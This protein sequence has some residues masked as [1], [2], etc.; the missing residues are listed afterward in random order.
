MTSTTKPIEVE[1]G[2]TL[3]SGIN[4]ISQHQIKNEKAGFSVD[5]PGNVTCCGEAAVQTILPRTRIVVPGAL[6]IRAARISAAVTDNLTLNR[7][8]HELM[9]KIDS[10]SPLSFALRFTAKRTMAEVLEAAANAQSESGGCGCGGGEAAIPGAVAIGLAPGAGGNL[11]WSDPISAMIYA[12][13]DSALD[14]GGTEKAVCIAVRDNCTETWDFWNGTTCTGMQ[15]TW[16]EDC[17]CDTDS[18]GK[19]VT[20]CDGWVRCNCN[21]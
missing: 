6:P 1:V 16:P 7:A 14:F 19:P 15:C 17:K 4:F 2:T 21:P 20:K 18:N 12:K 8:K 13:A 9:A 5:L 11:K 3:P 10:Q